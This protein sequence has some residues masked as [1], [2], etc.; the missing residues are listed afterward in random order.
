MV[1]FSRQM[2]HGLV[3][4]FV[5]LWSDQFQ[6]GLVFQ[7]VVRRH[8]LRA[9][10]ETRTDVFLTSGVSSSLDHELHRVLPLLT[11]TLDWKMDALEKKSIWTKQE[12]VCWWSVQRL[13]W[14]K[15]K[16]YRAYDSIATFLKSKNYARFSGHKLCM[17]SR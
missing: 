5:K 14:A 15:W 1:L 12:W 11:K 8:P 6:R 4:A 2:T 7:Q 17:D 3:Y 10:P 9:K 16:K 13:N